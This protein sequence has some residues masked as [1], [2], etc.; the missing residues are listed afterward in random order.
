MDLL[1]AL[2]VM[3]LSK[4]RR[5]VRV[6]PI[7]KLKLLLGGRAQVRAIRPETVNVCAIE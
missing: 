5:A 6:R 4:I 7:Y 3:S 1:L 2:A